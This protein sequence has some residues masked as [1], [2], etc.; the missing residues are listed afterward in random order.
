MES[1]KI[2]VHEI[3][4]ILE[5]TATRIP[6]LIN[7]LIGTLYSAEAGRNMGQAVGNLYTELVNAGL[8]KEVAVEMAKE[9]MLSI[10]QILRQS[11][12]SAVPKSDK[13]DTREE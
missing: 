3:S 6:K 4:E 13:E 1:D 8:P 5:V 2:P 12:E 9:Y 7:G 11:T 10:K